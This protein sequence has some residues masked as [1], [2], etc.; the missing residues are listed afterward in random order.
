MNCHVF[1]D[2]GVFIV[3][4]CTLP[5]LNCIAAGNEEPC[6]IAFIFFIFICRLGILWGILP[7]EE[8]DTYFETARLLEKEHTDRY[9]SK[10]FSF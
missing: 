6:F 10:N 8:K 1:T 5:Q 3:V 7:D 2:V 9:P 4:F